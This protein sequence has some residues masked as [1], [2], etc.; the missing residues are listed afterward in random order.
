MW[1]SQMSLKKTRIGN[2]TGDVNDVIPGSDGRGFLVILKKG[3]CWDLNLDGTNWF[4]SSARPGQFPTGLYP[5][6]KYPIRDTPRVVCLDGTVSIVKIVSLS[7]RVEN[8]KVKKVIKVSYLNQESRQC[9]ECFS[10]SYACERL[11]HLYIS[12]ISSSSSSCRAASTDIPD[13]LSPLLPII[14]RLRQV[15]WLTSRVLT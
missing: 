15:F 11:T 4:S 9:F 3:V 1:Q 8:L 5:I 13:P 14:H 7:S 6:N 10:D 12:I 2:M